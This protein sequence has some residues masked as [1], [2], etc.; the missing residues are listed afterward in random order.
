[1]YY[2]HSGYKTYEQTGTKV[3][4]FLCKYSLGSNDS[5][6]KKLVDVVKALFKLQ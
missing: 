2:F 5:D 3:V 1:M 6:I 4:L